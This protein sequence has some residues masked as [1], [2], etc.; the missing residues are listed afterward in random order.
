M[1]RAA[2]FLTTPFKSGIVQNFEPHPTANS[3]TG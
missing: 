1:F 3:L 2:F